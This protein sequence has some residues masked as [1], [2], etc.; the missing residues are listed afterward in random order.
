MFY[1]LSEAT[2]IKFLKHFPKPGNL[3]F[4]AIR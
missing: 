1:K 4:V 3:E 2:T